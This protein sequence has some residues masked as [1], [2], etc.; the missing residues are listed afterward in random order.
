M[1]R[2]ETTKFLPVP[3]V[4]KY[5]NV[6]GYY[7]TKTGVRKNLYDSMVM[8][9]NKDNIVICNF[10]N[11]NEMVLPMDEGIY[12]VVPKTS[13]DYYKEY[14][15][16]VTRL[17]RNLL[18]SNFNADITNHTRDNNCLCNNLDELIVNY[19]K[20]GGMY[21]IIGAVF[22]VTPHYLGEDYYDAGLVV[23]YKDDNEYEWFHVRRDIAEELCADARAFLSSKGV[24]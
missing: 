23:Q 19:F 6:S 13:D 10:W 3:Q 4:Q 11:N 12:L 1:T 17:C 16:T 24:K 15:E 20:D 14:P 22:D 18:N 8:T 2:Y 5:Q 21:E 7:N 9:V